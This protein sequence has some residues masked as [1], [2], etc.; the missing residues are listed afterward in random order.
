MKKFLLSL[1]NSEN[2]NSSKRFAGLST[3]GSAILL[4]F[5]ATVKSGWVC[6]EFMFNGLLMV[7]AGLFGFNMA[8]N[9]F[10]GKTAT[11]TNVDT[12]TPTVVA[13]GATASAPMQTGTTQVDNPDA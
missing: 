5:V 13:I 10:K 12:I 9:I 11:T 2:L 7:V 3:L 6:P 4:A 8:E 1:V